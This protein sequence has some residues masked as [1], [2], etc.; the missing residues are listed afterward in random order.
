MSDEIKNLKKYLSKKG[1]G[2]FL[3]INKRLT[4]LMGLRDT[5]V[6]M[7]IVDLANADKPKKDINGF[8]IATYRYIG[9]DIDMSKETVGRAVSNLVKYKFIETKVVK[10]KGKETRLKYLVHP[11]NIK[12]VIDNNELPIERLDKKKKKNKIEIEDEEDFLE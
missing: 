12:A 10:G 5:A 11:R 3:V 2:F 8:F 9:N 4:N 1:K 7:Q 6:L